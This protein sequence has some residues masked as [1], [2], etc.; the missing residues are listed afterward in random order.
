MGNKR[1]VPLAR[2]VNLIIVFTLIAGIGG[3]SFYFSR[4]ISSTIDSSTKDNLR[5]QSDIL[6]T[7][8]E[9]FMLPGQAPAG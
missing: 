7:A 6:Y 2:K 1:I 8:I 9:N 5:R 3:I 4:A